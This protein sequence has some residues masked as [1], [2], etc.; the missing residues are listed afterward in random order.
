MKRIRFGLI[1][2]IA[3]L[4]IAVEVAGFSTLGWF[5]ASRFAGTMEE[6]LH[7]RLRLAGQMIADEEMSVSVVARNQLMSD[8]VGWPYLG[9]MVVGGNGLV[10]ASSDPDHLGRAAVDAPGFDPAWFAPDGPAIRYVPGQDTMMAVMHLHGRHAESPLFHTVLRVST[11]QLQAMKRHIFVQGLFVSLVFILLTSAAIVLIAQR[12]INR[13]VQQSLQ[14]LK[15]VEEGA[16]D[17]RIPVDGHDELGQLQQGINSMTAKLGELLEQHRRHAQELGAQK[18]LLQSIID[19]APIRVFWKD[20]EST[21]LGCNRS[22]ARDAGCQEAA[23]LIG[24]NDFELGWHDQA[25]LYRADDRAVMTA[26]AE[27]LLFEEPQTTPDGQTI[28]LLTSKVPLRDREGGVIGVLGIYADITEKKRLDAEL[29]VHRNHLEQLV[30][31]RTAELEVALAAAE[32]ANV[33]KSAFLANMSH[34]IRTPL[35]AITGMSHLIRRG[36]LSPHQAEQMD[37]ILAAKIGRAHV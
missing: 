26:G 12:L 4:A 11:D 2:R 10:I 1:V 23:E 33:A 5:Y 31:Q 7:N 16:L 15:A 19:T 35:N 20:R 32:A 34:E 14:V 22:F 9:G 25:E 18:D 27:K 6:R 24:R 21:Y 37:K 3:L 13:R 28:W 36:G 8:L 17:A 30:Q 29:E